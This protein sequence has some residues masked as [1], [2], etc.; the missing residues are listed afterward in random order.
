MGR[1]GIAS[2]T[3]R[4]HWCA[5][6]LRVLRDLRLQGA[7]LEGRGREVFAKLLARRDLFL[8]EQASPP[9]PPFV[10]SGH[11]ASLTPY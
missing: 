3:V 9:P 5:A 11:A 7:R 8:D 2:A 1:G 6:V 4:R 10:L